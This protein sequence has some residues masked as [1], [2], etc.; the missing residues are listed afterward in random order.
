[1]AYGTTN[2]ITWVVGGM[3][4]GNYDKVLF[5]PATFTAGVEYQSNSM[6]LSNAGR[7]SS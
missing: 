7:S 1:M 2:D 6:R 3:Y 5:S 4:V